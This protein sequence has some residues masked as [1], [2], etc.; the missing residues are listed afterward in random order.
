MAAEN[1]VENPL[2]Y[3][4]EKASWTVADLRRALIGPVRRHAGPAPSVRRISAHD[5][6][7][8][9]RE[10]LHD[11]GVARADVAFLAVI[12]PIAG[13]VLARLA[14]SLDLLPLV[15]PL[16]SGFA[17][18]GPV[19]AIGLYEIS[20]RI[21]AGEEVGWTVAFRVLRSPAL[22]SIL[23]LGAVLFLLFF[24]WLAAA[25]GIYAA[26]LG[27]ESPNSLGGFVRDVFQTSAG[28][29]MIVAGTLVGFLFAAAAFALSVVSFPLMLDRDVDMMTAVRTSLRA[30]ARN[31][32]VM[33]L[34]GAIIAGALILGFIPALAGLIFVMPVL[35]HAS[36]RLYRRVVAPV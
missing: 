13:L 21:E 34:W 30:C 25:W 20:R 6:A 12:Y 8:A 24:A 15:L 31:P 22:S 28:W 7:A 33:A 14:F 35:G 26:T 19:A 2:E 18:I 11:L 9:L 27:P 1:H 23:G 5:L 32:G 29:T 4:L 16:V 36:W 17:L 3:V 10:G